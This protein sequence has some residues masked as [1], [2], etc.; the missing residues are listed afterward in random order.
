MHEDVVSNLALQKA[1][2]GIL[3]EEINRLLS[4]GSIV[5]HPAGTVL[6]LEDNVEETFYILLEGEVKVTKS[7]SDTENRLL[8]YLASGDF[9]GEMGIIHEAPRAAS[10]TTTSSSTVLEINKE[11]FEEVLH[12]SSVVSLAMVKEVSKRLRENDEMA[13]EDLRIKAGELAEAYQQL[14]ELDLARREFLTTI[15]HELRTPLTSAGGYMQVIR[16]GMVEGEEL[17]SALDTVS[18]N[19]DQIVSLTNDIL[20]LQE[21][22]LILSE[23]ETIDIGSLITG[24]VESERDH[25][26]TMKVVMNINIAPNFPKIKGDLKSLER[27]F[28]AIINNAIKFSING[29][30]VKINIDQNP[31]FVWVSIRDDGLGIEEE[32][33]PLIFNRFWRTEEYKGRL[34]GG[35]GLGLSIARQVIEQHGGEIEVTSTVGEGTNFIVRLKLSGQPEIQYK[36]LN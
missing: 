35:V 33:L 25:A 28:S 18:R 1:F 14:A 30:E 3:T 36:S 9:F 5:R 4:K 10:V 29:G 20:F 6:C 15:A 13:I 24:L 32:D 19:I 23:F 22:D 27:A 7:I 21:M 12:Q 17:N 11:S 2:P 8:K 16:S 31:A 26:E 34:F